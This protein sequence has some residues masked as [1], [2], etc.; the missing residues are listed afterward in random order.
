[1]DFD[2]TVETVR[3]IVTRLNSPV[4]DFNL[5][6]S[7]SDESVEVSVETTRQLDPL[8]VFVVDAERLRVIKDTEINPDGYKSVTYS[9]CV[10]LLSHILEN[11]YP[12]F[13]KINHG[14]SIMEMLSRV[15]GENIRIWKDLIRVICEAGGVELFNFGDTVSLLDTNF[16]YNLDSHTLFISGKIEESVRCVSVMELVVAILTIID[17]LL[18]RDEL[19]VNPI[20]KDGLVNED[21]VGFDFDG[22]GDT[23]GMESDIDAAAGGFGDGADGFG[24]E[25][26]LA[27]EFEPSG[28]E[29]TNFAPDVGDGKT[30]ILDEVY[31]E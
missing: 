28:D 15:F 12:I 7:E 17:F 3:A 6:F 16:T 14:V 30:E 19:E 4:S 29:L 27:D 8:F 24:G 13:S 10:E 9:G 11:F 1:L 25:D 20:L 31:D 26:D 21:E 23:L 22:V 2:D 5:V 18:K